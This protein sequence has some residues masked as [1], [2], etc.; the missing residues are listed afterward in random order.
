MQLR[1]DVQL[2]EWVPKGWGQAGHIL[3]S[4]FILVTG[5]EHIFYPTQNSIGKEVLGMSHAKVGQALL[6]RLVTEGHYRWLDDASAN[7]CSA[8]SC[9]AS[10]SR[11]WVA[12]SPF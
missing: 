8:L 12:S 10:L 1:C 11:V 3:R 2:I 7:A 4:V 5:G 9:L 6:D